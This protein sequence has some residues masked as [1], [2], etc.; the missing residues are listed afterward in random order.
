LIV[1]LAIIGAVAALTRKLPPAVN[2]FFAR[3]LTFYT[4]FMTVVYSL[5]PYKTPW[6]MLGFLH[7]MILLAGLG[8]V[9]LLR[10][11]P[12]LGLKFVTAVL[13]LAAGYNLATQAHM[14]S[15]RLCADNRN[16]YVYAH[17]STDLLNLVQRVEDIAAIH[18]QQH[19]MIIQ[20]IAEDRDYWPLPWYLRSFDRGKIGYYNQMPESLPASLI[21]IAPRF[22]NE[23]EAKLKDKYHHEIFGLRPAVPL[24]VYI[25][26]DLWQ[27][28]LDTRR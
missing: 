13:L 12:T 7:G 6:C 4:L 5:L 10:W 15:F 24:I 3:F 27:K 23:L 21:I 8:V 20:I 25:R 18:P 2:L 19:N 26:D 9:A 28:F 22:Q 1:F 11:I 16:P 17:T 14:A